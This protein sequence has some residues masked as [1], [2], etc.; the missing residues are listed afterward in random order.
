[1]VSHLATES[2]TSGDVKAVQN[3]YRK[4]GGGDQ[5]VTR[6]REQVRAFFGDFQLV[7]PGLVYVSQ[8]PAGALRDEPDVLA[9][10]PRRSG[11]HAGVAFKAPQAGNVSVAPVGSVAVGRWG[12]EHA[13]ALMPAQD[14][15]LL[16]AGDGLLDR[17]R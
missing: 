8:W 1:V 13:K 11:G 6:T 2:F 9:Q 3:I 14:A 12:D 5:P 17:R 16:E 15:G 10:D 7:D 4:H